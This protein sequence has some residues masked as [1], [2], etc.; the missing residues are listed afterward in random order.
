MQ[1]FFKNFK[2]TH[3]KRV[4]LK[5]ILITISIYFEIYLFLLPSKTMAWGKRGHSIICQTAAYLTAIKAF[6]SDFLKERS[7][8]IGYY[9]NVPDL[10]WLKGDLYKK[11][12]FNHFMDMEIFIR[13]FKNVSVEN[14]FSLSRKEFEKTFPNI[15]E[16]AGRAFWRVNELISF[17]E[18]LSAQLNRSDLSIEDRHKLQ[19]NWLLYSGAIGHYLGDLSQPLHVTENYDG[20]LSDQ[21]G[22]HAMIQ[23]HILL[24]SLNLIKRLVERV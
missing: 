17:V 23:T 12:W 6:R 3:E 19:A 13:E 22:I 14:P 15:K 2:P 9:C 24:N 11:E 20:Q 8:D 4:I 5:A 18:K 1:R 10:I 16:E 21:S 7:F